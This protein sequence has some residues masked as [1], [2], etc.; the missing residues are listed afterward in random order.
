MYVAEGWERREE[1]GRGGM[2]GEGMKG[3]GESWR[4]GGMKR[5]RG[6][7]AGERKGREGEGGREGGTHM[8]WS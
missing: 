8:S 5:G 2:E 1:G 7:I 4:E 6:G 3:G